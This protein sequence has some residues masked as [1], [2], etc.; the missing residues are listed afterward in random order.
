MIQHPNHKTLGD[1]VLV[2]KSFLEEVEILLER[3]RN[4]PTAN[5][6]GITRKQIMTARLT[7][8]L[9][10]LADKTKQEGFSHVPILDE[11]DV[12]IGA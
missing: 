11:N 12:V 3:L 10:D 6:V 4:P 8:Q 2:S 7:D 5:S 9:G 1:A